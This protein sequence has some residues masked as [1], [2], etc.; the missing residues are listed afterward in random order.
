MSAVRGE[1]VAASPTAAGSGGRRVALEHSLFALLPALVCGFIVYEMV[2]GHIVAID[3]RDAYWV[4][5]HRLLHGTSPYAWTHAQITGGEVFVY[6]SLAALLM[7]PFAILPS[8]AAAFLFSG[9]CAAAAAAT[10]RV[11][12]VRDWR[13]Y[14]LTL[15]WPWVVAGW[16]TG[17]L[18]LLLGLGIALA[19]RYRDRP[20]VTGLLV[21]VLV[22]L[23]P[24]TAPIALWLLA[25]RRYAALGWAVAGGAALN[26]V[27][28]GVVGFDQIRRYVDLSSSVTSALEHTGY[29]AISAAQHIGLGQ[30]AGVVIELL[31]AVGLV[32][33][34]VMAGRRQA[35]RIALTA[36][37]M[38]M[39]VAWPLVWSHYF[40]L[41]LIPI[42]IASPRLSRVWLLPL[43]L[44]GCAVRGAAEWQILLTWAVVA[45]VCFEVV[46]PRAQPRDIAC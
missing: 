11:L 40:A 37:I 14:G 45:I 3:F 13:L 44:W 6:P 21:G 17:N 18:T 41:L 9:L 4:A 15:V 28:W 20:V 24:F 33:L 31:A 34:V 5:G 27:G 46:R 23:K 12:E 7:V 39:L 19:W 2:R 42:A 35:D 22:S 36:A 32:A 10:L 38:L 29:G 30:S 1:V 16:Q 43:V 25:T 26:L 8:S